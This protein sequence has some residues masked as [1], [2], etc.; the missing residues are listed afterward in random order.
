MKTFPKSTEQIQDIVAALLV[1]GTGV[2]LAYND[3]AGTLTISS[4]VDLTGY[5]TTAYVD[6]E[7]SANGV[8]LQAFSSNASNLTSGTVSDNRLSGNVPLKN[9]ANTFTANQTI[10]TL[11]LPSLSATVR[12]TSNPASSASSTSNMQ[13]FLTQLRDGVDIPLRGYRGRWIFDISAGGPVLTMGDPAGPENSGFLGDGF[14]K[15]IG[16][17][18][19]GLWAQNACRF[20]VGP[21]YVGTTNAIIGWNT[22]TT[23]WLDTY[24]KKTAVGSVSLCQ[25]P[26]NTGE[27]AA[28]LACGTITASGTIDSTSFRQT[29]NTTQALVPSGGVWYLD[30]TGGFRYRDTSAGYATKFQVDNAGNLTASGNIRLDGTYP[31]VGIAPTAWSGGLFYVQSGVNSIVTGAG[32][33]TA[34]QNPLSKSFVWTSGNPSTTGRTHLTIDGAT[35]N[36]TFGGNITLSGVTKFTGY[37]TS[38]LPAAASNAGAITYD[39]TI[40]KHV[41]CNGSSWNALW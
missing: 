32:D 10:T 2:T 41:G 31:W 13:T 37:P 5:A 28:S 8:S 6:D 30:G 38:L 36:A 29:G 35:S 19:A 40:S 33:F 11:V 27:V 25:N 18:H 7:V 4:S 17:G 15:P 9:A 34:F 20:W 24:F 26:S 21:S 12:S 22:S 1:E 39:T 23:V 16:N 14:G 3:G